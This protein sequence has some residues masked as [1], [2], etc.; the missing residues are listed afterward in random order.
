MST[1][2]SNFSTYPPGK[3]R[4]RVEGSKPDGLTRDEYVKELKKEQ[5]WIA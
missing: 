5:V 3:K 2:V 4:A 1:K